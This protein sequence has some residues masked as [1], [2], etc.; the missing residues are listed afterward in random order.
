MGGRK[1]SNEALL[2]A[3]RASLTRGD[4]RAAWPAQ[5]SPGTPWPRAPRPGAAPALREAPAWW[6][7]G[8]AA[9][10]PRT[11]TAAQATAP[12]HAGPRHVYLHGCLRPRQPLGAGGLWA[13]ERLASPWGRGAGGRRRWRACRARQDAGRWL[14][15][16]A[17]MASA[18][19]RVLA[20]PLTTRRG[21]LGVCTS[22]ET[23][24]SSVT[25]GFAGALAHVT[26]R[27]PY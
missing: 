27:N 21:L 18:P 1:K 19:S 9:A 2:Q 16:A 23:T 8:P 17:S 11:T 10:G 7:G 5:A 25:G 22:R 6:R 13:R 12:R 4:K 20:G 15:S 3:P 14:V 24:W 26:P